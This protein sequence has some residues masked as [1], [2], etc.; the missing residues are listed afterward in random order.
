[1]RRFGLG[2]FVLLA[3]LAF[4][5][6][7][8]AAAACVPPSTQAGGDP[9]AQLAVE[10]AELTAAVPAQWDSFGSSVA[11]SGDTALVSAP[12][13]WSGNGDPG[14][15]YVFARSGTTWTQQA[16]LTCPD[17]TVTDEFGA[18]V[19]L[20]G[21]TA[22][23]GAPAKTIDGQIRAGAAYVFTG[24][25]ASW[26]QEA[27]LSDPDPAAGDY[28]GCSVALS[29]ETALVGACDK[30]SFGAAYVYTRLGTNWSQEAELTG[31]GFS[32][33]DIVSGFGCS[34]AL[35]GETALVGAD[36]TGI[37][38]GYSATGAAFVFTRSGTS[39]SQ[40][41]EL[42]AFDAA[43]GEYLGRWVALSGDTALVGGQGEV[44]VTY[45]FTRSGTTW[46]QQAELKLV[47]F[48][49]AV[50]L[51]GDTAL[52]G[53]LP[54]FVDGQLVAGHAY[55]FTRSGT[56]WTQQAE[57]SDPSPPV[58][59]YDDSFGC[60]VAISGG[61]TLIGADGL[62]VDYYQDSGAAYVFTDTLPG[63]LSSF[64]P[65]VGPIG[66]SVT[67]TAAGFTGASAVTFNCVPAAF[68][69]IDD[70]TISATVP[71]GASSG[72]IAVTTP[73]G[74]LISAGDF[75]VDT[76]P[77]TTTDNTDGLWYRS[78]VLRLAT[79]DADSG[80][81]STEYRIDGSSWSTG[82]TVRLPPKGGKTRHAP[83]Q[84]DRLIEYRSTDNAGNVEQ[85][86]TCHVLID[87]T[88]PITTDNT[89]GLPH[90]CFR[91]LLTATDALSGVSITRYC[92]DG[93]PWE[94]GTSVP[95]GTVSRHLR[96]HPQALAPGTYTVSYYSIDNAGNVE[97]VKSCRV[98]LD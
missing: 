20:C 45:F 38:G 72:P 98:I 15:V 95:L 11:L 10:Q 37:V 21:H 63:N 91:L 81:A 36:E 62:E 55:L 54:Q 14:V 19:A 92:I 58:Y 7:S 77:P 39:W 6:P 93:G 9:L 46:T 97:S 16:E 69:V 85:I 90:T 5:V 32:S 1:M 94:T 96:H 80:V 28:F 82:T 59:L 49:G 78:F 52:V 57:L 18:A 43:D 40:Q 35:S 44:S 64:A 74:T 53:V 8:L 48:A 13:F 3:A 25:G 61:T 4:A 51:S 75:I 34:V 23:I 71:A 88:A 70:S 56:M 87:D 89:D 83:T 66:T 17:T 24:S 67:L 30:G 22:L 26:S 12:G 2:A 73:S 84:G 65:T 41:A 31:S 86:E 76:T 27:E 29:G 33:A 42:R 79:T 60:S 50:A 68:T 47:G